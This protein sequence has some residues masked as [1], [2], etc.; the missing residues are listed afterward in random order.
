MESRAGFFFVAQLLPFQDFANR[1][2]ANTYRRNPAKGVS[3]NLGTLGV[4][5]NRTRSGEASSTLVKK[6]KIGQPKKSD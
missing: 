4:L 1:K 3:L 6:N 5:R 2:S